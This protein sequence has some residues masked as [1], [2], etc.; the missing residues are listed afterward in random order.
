[1]SG[2]GSGLFF[3]RSRAFS[4][5]TN[6]TDGGSRQSSRL[7]DRPRSSL[8]T[9]VLTE[10]ALTPDTELAP[11]AVRSSSV[12]HAAINI[13]AEIMGAGVLSLPHAAADLGWVLG[14][15]ST[16]FFGAIGCY[17]GVILTRT[18][19]QFYPHAESFADL[20]LETCGRRFSAF[21]RAAICSQWALLLPY[22]LIACVSSLR[23][24]LPH[25][26]L[27][28]VEWSLVAAAA[29]LLPLQ[30]QTLHTLAYAGTLSTLAMLTATALVLSGL[31]EQRGGDP[32]GNVSVS[33]SSASLGDSR[34]LGAS[35]GRIVDGGDDGMAVYGG[36]SSIGSISSIGSTS[37]HSL[38]PPALV[39]PGGLR[40][41][42]LL[43]IAGSLCAVVFAYQGDNLPR[44]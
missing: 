26:Q 17:T 5:L 30:C 44:G 18:K 25:I 19:T 31:F 12:A 2:V 13:V 20:A 11:E 42:G 7:S 29:L 40:G 9:E 35:A 34:V 27:C 8:L 36:S 21:T 15:G 32:S 22:F 37:N 4:R 23:L 3:P 38:W 33:S 41:D 39:D 10:E 6:D 28:F 16:A 1:M 14:L 43:E 24:G